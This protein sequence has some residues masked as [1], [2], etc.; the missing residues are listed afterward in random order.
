MF[1]KRKTRTKPNPHPIAKK[2]GWFGKW[3]DHR[4]A[5]LKVR[6]KSRGKL[7][8][9]DTLL[10]WSNIAYLFALAIVSNSCFGLEQQF[11]LYLV[12]LSFCSSVIFHTT[13]VYAHDILEQNDDY[14][15]VYITDLIDNV[16]AKTLAVFCS[17]VMVMANANLFNF[18]FASVAILPLIEGNTLPWNS[19][20]YVHSLW[21]FTGA[22]EIAYAFGGYCIR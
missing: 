2:R 22:A 15:P 16:F 3:L 13:E 12:F 8:W 4:K 10:I 19:Y 5:Q 21:H 18:I 14:T 6:H 17:Y 9:K 11:G 7:N 1:F 20:V